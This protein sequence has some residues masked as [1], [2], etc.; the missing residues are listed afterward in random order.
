MPL[1]TIQIVGWNNE[2]VLTP[3]LKALAAIPKGEVEIRF[4]DNGSTDNSVDL[5]KKMLPETDI[6]ELKTNTGF[7]YAHNV[8]FSQCTTEFVLVLNPDIEIQWEGLKK[9]LKAFED[10]SV[11]A[12]QGKLLRQEKSANGEALLDSA[13]IMLSKALNGIER[14]SYEEDRGQYEQQADILAVTGACGMYRMSA[15]KTVDHGVRDGVFEI[16]DNAFFA[17]KEDVDLG[18]RLKRAGWTSLYL[19]IFVAHH[20]RSLGR[21]GFMNWGLSPKTIY[22]RMRSPR[23]RYS[24]RNWIWMMAKNMTFKQELKAELFID[25]RL[26]TF[27][28]LSLLYPPFFKVWLETLHGLPEM[29][30]KRHHTLTK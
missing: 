24:F 5:V 17:Y 14:G 9:L 1:L 30:R 21:R 10:P 20:S 16:F 12:V 23:T 19:P 28:C 27:F 4:I 18:W 26:A 7:A 22:T 6:V 8:G 11:A 25:A 2:Q 13:G 15:L 3:G 29:F